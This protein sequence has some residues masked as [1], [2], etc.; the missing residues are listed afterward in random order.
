MHWPG[1]PS[2]L[3]EEGRELWEARAVASEQQA[4]T[5]ASPAGWPA[6]RL[7]PPC[8]AAASSSTP[9]LSRPSSSS[10]LPPPPYNFFP[11]HCLSAGSQDG[12]RCRRPGQ[13]R[14]QAALAPTSGSGWEGRARVRCSVRPGGLGSFPDIQKVHFEFS[15]ARNPESRLNFKFPPPPRPS[16]GTCA[17]TC[18]RSPR[19][20]FLREFHLAFSVR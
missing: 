18:S 11:S 9:P 13:A 20:R 1:P 2:V 10:S 4:S 15:E 12:R 3:R 5:S 7:S 6:G 8:P 16:D 19:L 14:P 17:V